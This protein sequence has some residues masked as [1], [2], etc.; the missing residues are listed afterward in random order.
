MTIGVLKLLNLIWRFIKLIL[1]N[2]ICCLDCINFCMWDSSFQSYRSINSYIRWL[3]LKIQLWYMELELKLFLQYYMNILI[4]HYASN[5]ILYNVLY[6]KYILHKN[7]ENRKYFHWIKLN[8]IYIEYSHNKS[9]PYPFY[10][11]QGC[12]KLCIKA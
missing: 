5:N 12:K 3:T 10:L 8:Y 9:L 11:F 7:C 1:G 4:M 2:F 6:Y